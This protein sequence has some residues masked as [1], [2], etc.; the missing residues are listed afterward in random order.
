MSYIRDLLRQLD[1][2]GDGQSTV[3]DG[4]LHVDVLDL[5][6]QIGLC[7]DKAN[8]A[9]LDLEC[10]IGAFLDGLAQGTG[11]LDNEVLA[12][13]SSQVV[14]LV[15]DRSDGGGSWIEAPMIELRT[16]WEDLGRGQHSRC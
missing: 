13:I 16:P 2:L 9:V 3:F 6:A 8:Q 14:L 4:A 12:T 5:L 7:A 10:D 11:C 1:G 15:F